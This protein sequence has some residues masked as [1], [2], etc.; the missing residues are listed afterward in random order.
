[1]FLVEH[2]GNGRFKVELTRVSPGFFDNDLMLFEF[3]GAVWSEMAW[4]VIHGEWRAPRPDEE[5]QLVVEA[6][7][8]WQVLMLQPD[9]GQVS[10][11]MPFRAEGEGGIHLIGPVRNLGRPLLVRG[12]HRAR[13]PFYAQ[14]LPLDG[15]LEE[16][17]FIEIDG[18]IYVEDHPTEMMAGKEYLIEVG[19][20]GRWELE[21]YEGY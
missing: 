13:G 1:M 11:T 6:S 3:Q 12:Q 5:Y 18:Q 14:A 17:N 8:N 21:F 7:G 20:N 9:L 15:S 2:G 16:H 10:V 19:A 4:V